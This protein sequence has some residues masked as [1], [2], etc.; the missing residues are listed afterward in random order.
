MLVQLEFNGSPYL[1]V[2][3]RATDHHIL[4]PPNLDASIERALAEA[5][6]APVHP[7]TLGGSYLVGSL[8]A[9]NGQGVLVPAF[10]TERELTVLRELGLEVAVLPG[11]FNAVGNNVLANDHG[12]LVN[13]DLPPEA[14]EAVA[15]VLG[16]EVAA[17]TVAGLRIVGSV[18][19]ATNR[20]VLAHPKATDDEL[21]LLEDLLGV[22]ADIGTVNH[23][24]PYLGA[25]MVANGVGAAIGRATTGPELNRIEDALGYLE[26]RS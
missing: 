17:G 8:L 22:E 12:A 1:G 11:R 15:A 21:D 20:G 5:L 10:T 13:P 19:V 6:E 25:G 3:A 4:L 18:A 26:P 14:R 16:V 23:G 9:A 7:I 24:A 2:F